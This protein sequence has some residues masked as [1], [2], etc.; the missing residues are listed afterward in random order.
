MSASLETFPLELQIFLKTAPTPTVFI[1]LFFIISSNLINF[2]KLHLI[3]YKKVRMFKTHSF[4]SKNDYLQNNDYLQLEKYVDNC[5]NKA[6]EICSFEDQGDI[7]IFLPRVRD[8][9]SAE[10]KLKVGLEEKNLINRVE[11]H[12]L[13]ARQPLEKQ[14]MITNGFHDKTYRRV[15]V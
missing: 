14:R 12:L 3:L 4:S 11:I 8:L 1:D 15:S 2:F 6:L 9:R 10:I 7:L 5:V 13:Y